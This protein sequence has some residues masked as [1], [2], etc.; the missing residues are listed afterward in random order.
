[1]NVQK[2][3]EC[4]VPDYVCE[5]YFNYTLSYAHLTNFDSI[6]QQGIP[7]S[8]D[9]I[10]KQVARSLGHYSS[11]RS[12]YTMNRWGRSSPISQVQ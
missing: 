5:K 6:R 7:I 3:T 4:N 9:D 11:G 12:I 10:I 1:M 2:K 8:Y